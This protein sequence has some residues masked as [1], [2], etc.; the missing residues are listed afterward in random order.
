MGASLYNGGPQALVWGCLLVVVGSLSQALSMAELGS[1]LPIAG[2]QY[3]WT[4]MLAPESSR[5][6]ITWFQG[7]VT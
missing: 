7:W 3:H 2:A 6:V 4:D 5:R 1:I